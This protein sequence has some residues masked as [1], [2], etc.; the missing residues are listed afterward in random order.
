C[1]LLLVITLLIAANGPASAGSF[2]KLDKPPLSERWFGIY[3]DNERV[4][5]Y[6]QNI[7]ATTEGYR[8]ESDGSVRLSVMG[9]SK[10][11]SSRES[12]LVGKNL[13]LRSFEVEQTISGTLSRVSGKVNDT[14]MRVRIES[15]GKT[16]ERQLKFKGDIYPGP[17]LN[18]YPLMRETTAGKSYKILTFD[19]EEIKLKEVTITILGEEQS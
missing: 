16:T 18:L 10:E 9:I 4:G 1:C 6:R 13:T 11:A 14:S 7:S 2:K 8:I 12:Y 15:N 19:P 3:L 17:A 5:F